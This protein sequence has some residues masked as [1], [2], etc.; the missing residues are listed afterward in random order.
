MILALVLYLFVNSACASTDE[1]V[2]KANVFVEAVEAK[3]P[4][5]DAGE[6]FAQ[7][8]QVEI[9]QVRR[10]VQSAKEMD[11]APEL[12]AAVARLHID[13]N[14]LVALDER[15]RKVEIT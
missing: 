8:E 5:W 12:L 9:A 2:S 3:L 13:W 1:E 10:D 15:L 4:E 6:M 7:Y 14:K 11:N